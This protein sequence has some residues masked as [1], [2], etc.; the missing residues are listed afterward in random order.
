M[1]TNALTVAHAL[2]GRLRLRVPAHVGA[3]GLAAAIGA[4]DGVVSCT[5]SPRTR[6]LLVRYDPQVTEAA[7]IVDRV[8]EHAGIEAPDDPLPAA[9]RTTMPPIGAVVP[10]MFSEANGSVAR[11]TRGVL[12]LGSGIPLL[13]VGWAAFELM[14]GRAAPLAWSSALWYAHGLFRDYN[15]PPSQS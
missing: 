11:A 1:T 13:L 2:P 8:A 12:D 5:W 15:L 9:G 7:T 6:G 4:L 10:A 3:E 14:R